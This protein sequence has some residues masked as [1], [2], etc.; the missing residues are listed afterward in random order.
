M[1]WHNNNNN[2][3]NNNKKQQ[4]QLQQQQQQQHIWLISVFTTVGVEWEAVWKCGNK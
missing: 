4:Q 2:N 1:C 3:N